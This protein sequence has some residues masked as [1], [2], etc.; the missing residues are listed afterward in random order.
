ML[1]KLFSKFIYVRLLYLVKY[2]S[3]ATYVR[4]EYENV[5]LKTRTIC[6]APIVQCHVGRGETKKPEKYS[7]YHKRRVGGMRE[8]D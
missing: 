2:W 4:L 5:C 7:R 6:R 8:A 1:P 3:A